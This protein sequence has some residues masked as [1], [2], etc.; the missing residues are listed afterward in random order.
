MH[1]SLPRLNRQFLT[2]LH[3]QYKI[4]PNDRVR[5]QA[6]KKQ[7]TPGID[8]F[9]E[10]VYMYFSFNLENPVISGNNIYSLSAPKKT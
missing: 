8:S 3:L 2:D 10:G 6:I 7:T 1:Q 5:Q 4:Q 9:T